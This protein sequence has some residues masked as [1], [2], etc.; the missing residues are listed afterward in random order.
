M[1]ALELAVIN[2]R[3]TRRRSILVWRAIPNSQLEWKP[4]PQAL[5]F[6]ETIRHVWDGTYVYH[7]LLLK[8]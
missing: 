5:S 1:T 3:E 4:D 6:G 8:G 2:L 7:Q